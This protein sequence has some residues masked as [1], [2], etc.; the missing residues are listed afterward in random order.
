MV[1]YGFIIYRKGIPW[2]AFTATEDAVYGPPMKGLDVFASPT[3][4]RGFEETAKLLWGNLSLAPSYPDDRD[5]R[6]A[7]ILEVV[8]RYMHSPYDNTYRVGPLRR[9]DHSSDDPIQI[10]GLV[11][12]PEHLRA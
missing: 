5:E 4:P 6:G 1:L 9:V 3:A 12:S 10:P 11:R 7:G 2:G 8:R